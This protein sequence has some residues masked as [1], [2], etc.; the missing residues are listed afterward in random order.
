MT[1]AQLVEVASLLGR[2]DPV[3]WLF[4]GD[5]VTAG[6][7]RTAG[8]RD[9]TQLFVERLRVELGR[10][11]DLVLNTAVPGWRVEDLLANL[12]HALLRHEA[13]VLI[14]GIGLNHC[15]D[16]RSG[17]EPFHA[18]LRTLLSE[19]TRFETRVVLQ[20]PNGWEPAADPAGPSGHLAAYADAIRA[21]ADEFATVLVDH[22]T[23]WQR[24]PA[25]TVE[26]WMAEG[27]HPNGIG[28]RVLAGSLLREFGMWEPSSDTC[29]LIRSAE[30]LA[31]ELAMRKRH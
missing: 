29:S 22:L 24:A 10:G 31:E 15:R 23:V 2:T 19:V 11:S 18:A 7:R 12:D 17:V 1:G 16:G 20:V 26:A 25:A 5:S 4:A 28:H 30:G 9:Y 14:L 8:L 21:C 3:T 13:D 6:S 27:C